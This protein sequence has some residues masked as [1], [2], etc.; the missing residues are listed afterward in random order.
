MGTAPFVQ[1]VRCKGDRARRY[2]RMKLNGDGPYELKCG[3]TDGTPCL[4][5][6]TPWGAIFPLGEYK[7]LDGARKAMRRVERK[8]EA[9]YE[10]QFGCDGRRRARL[11]KP[12]Q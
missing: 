12:K 4:D 8:I 1:A 11:V 9:G 5:I 2:E 10:L 6:W 7:S 3:T